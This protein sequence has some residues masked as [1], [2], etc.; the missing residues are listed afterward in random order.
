[1]DALALTSEKEYRVR[2]S[3]SDG[4]FTSFGKNETKVAQRDEFLFYL[5]RESSISS[6]K[7]ID[8]II[9]LI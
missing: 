4:D 6:E 8:C 3:P 9:D 2:E 1:M 5:N 7:R